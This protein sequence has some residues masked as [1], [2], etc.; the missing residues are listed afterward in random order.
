MDLIFFLVFLSERTQ[1]YFTLHIMPNLI[2]TYTYKIQV[3]RVR[4]KGDF[5]LSKK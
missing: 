1:K 4:K 5:I 2:G 3:K